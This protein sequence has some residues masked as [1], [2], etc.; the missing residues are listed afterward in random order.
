V[1]PIGYTILSQILSLRN[2]SVA[3]W[4]SDSNGVLERGTAEVCLKTVGFLGQTAE[5]E[6]CVMSSITFP[7]ALNARVSLA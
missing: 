7:A 1:Q 3:E 5:L 4:H 2:Q 6:G